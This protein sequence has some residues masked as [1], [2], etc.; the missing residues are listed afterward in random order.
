[1]GMMQEIGSQ[2][3]RTRRTAG[4][5]Q[6]SLARMTNLSR[7]TVAAIEAGG[8]TTTG[9]L[10]RVLAA[11]GL[12]LVVAGPQ[13]LAGRTEPLD[14]PTIK[15]LMRFERLRRSEAGDAIPALAQPPAA[16]LSPAGQPAIKGLMRHSE[17]KR[18]GGNGK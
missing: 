12:R 13:A 3:R 1:M 2:V 17:R 16:Q 9:A 5:S 10:D 4:L 8:S 15:D 11:L 18:R 7:P 14:R 6:A